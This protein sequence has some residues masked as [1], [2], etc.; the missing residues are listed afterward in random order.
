LIGVFSSVVRPAFIFFLYLD[1]IAM[2]TTRGFTLVELLVVIAIIGILVA[3]LLPAVQAARESAR[4]TQCT[5]NLK[6]LG[7]GAHNFHDTYKK[8]PPAVMMNTSVTDPA[9]NSQNFGPNWAVLIL[10]YIEQGNLYD[11]VAPSVQAYMNNPSEAGWRNLRGNTIQAYLCPSDTGADSPYSGNGGNWARGNYG[12]NAGPDMF[13]VGAGVQSGT[14]LG[15]RIGAPTGGGYPTSATAAPVM[16]VNSTHSMALITDG[17]SNTAMFDELRIGPAASDSRGTWALGQVGASL[18]AGSGRADTPYPNFNLSGGD[19][20]QGCTDNTAIGMG[21]CSGCG[22]WQVVARSRHPGGVLS[23]FA[24][25]SVR[26]IS[27][28]VGT[29]NWYYLHSASDGVSFTLE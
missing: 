27:N 4:R 6:Q 14:P 29:A 7:L 2:R 3:L 8:L 21:C 25:G 5:N 22:N 10:P 11:T 12:A 15:T 24:D 9:N 17:T 13:W 18:I 20:I 16:G 1:A 26:F 28:T 23:C 19:D